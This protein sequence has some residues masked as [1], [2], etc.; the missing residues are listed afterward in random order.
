MDC[1][2]FKVFAPMSVTTD[3][4]DRLGYGFPRAEQFFIDLRTHLTKGEFDK[5]QA[6]VDQGLD[7][8]GFQED[9]HHQTLLGRM[10]SDKQDGAVRG[11][12]AMGANPKV[13]TH[14]RHASGLALP[15]EIATMAALFEGRPDNALSRTDYAKSTFDALLAP[16]VYTADEIASI[17]AIADIK[18]VF[19][20]MSVGGTS[21]ESIRGAGW[22]HVR[23][24]LENRLVALSLDETLPAGTTPRRK[25]L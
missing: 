20:P 23:D 4:L 7:L 6:W 11:L 22:G 15:L 21:G 16:D 8:D 25:V 5:V 1:L 10:T 18:S 13:L 19:V 3:L 14:V 24:A 2:S 17:L 9:I 12:L